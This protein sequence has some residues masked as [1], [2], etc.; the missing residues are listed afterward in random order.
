MVSKGS[1]RGD[2]HEGTTVAGVL[3][4]GVSNWKYNGKKL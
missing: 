4:R 3:L 2:G 1:K